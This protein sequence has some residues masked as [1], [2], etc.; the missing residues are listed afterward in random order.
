VRTERAWTK[1]ATLA[2]ALAFAAQWRGLHPVALTLLALAAWFVVA[3]RRLGFALGSAAVVVG[4]MSLV[5][6][7]FT[8]TPAV[9]ADPA[10]AVGVALVVA[11]AATIP[12]VAKVAPA[13]NWEGAAGAMLASLSGAT[14]W[15]GGLAWGL[16]APGGGGLSW[17][18]YNDATGAV[19]GLR[20]IIRYGGVPSV[21]KAAN[22]VPLS[23]VLSASLLPPG[24][25][26][27][28]S[29]ASVAAQLSAHALQWGVLIAL[30]SL[31]AGLIVVALGSRP[32]R[33]GWPTL[34]G[35]SCASILLLA[36]PVTGRIL[37]LGQ[38]NAFVTMV[39]VGASVLAGVGARRHLLLSLSVLLAA[40][41]LL[42]VSWTPFAAVPGLLALV[43]ARRAKR[44][45]L[46]RQRVL[47]WMLP[48]CTVA[49]WTML[50][51]G[52]VLLKA[53]VKTD[54]NANYAT[55]KTFSRPGYWEAIGNPYWWP[56]SIAIVLVATLLAMLLR[57]RARDAAILMGLSTAG[58]VLGMLPF[59]LL[60]RR[61]PVNL[62]YYPAKYL[63]IATICLVPIVVGA[64]L[65][66]FTESDG[67]AARAATGA[68][69][70]AV[71]ALAIA[72]P[73]PPDTPRWAFTPLMI[74]RGQHYG[75]DAQVAGRIVAFT[76]NDEL[77][78]PWR[79]DPPFDTPVAMMDSSIGPPVDDVFL[80]PMRYV[81]RYYRNDFSAE[82]ACQLADA[83]VIPVVL[84]TRDPLLPEEVARSCPDARITVQLE[85]TT[86]N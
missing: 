58:L 25:V 32:G 73:T 54:P 52:P 4:W 9:G 84:V 5:L 42:V 49:A 37:D 60:T 2:G 59:L 10:I 46:D 56:L 66:V 44:A 16:H 22:S 81:L 15:I 39:L 43:V 24:T 61:L 65:R 36:A 51:Y 67:R 50:V 38:S 1:A 41:G 64:A 86:V 82:V 29:P 80:R 40:M 83:S 26:A 53:F 6:A 74:A 27:D 75:T 8:V 76:S 45:G 28:A 19:W 77:V 63:S 34:V 47:A 17:A 70:L 12:T 78:V 20:T 85:P 11:I 7:V 33:H 21:P 31:L 72:A 62:D 79:Y 69:V 55:V 18:M 48:G 35:A 13:A 68:S 71:C 57:R 30:A 3:V 23:D 14:L